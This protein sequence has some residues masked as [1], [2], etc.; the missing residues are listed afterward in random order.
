MPSVNSI[1][2]LYSKRTLAYS[3]AKIVLPLIILSFVACEN[4]M[5]K[6]PA[7]RKKQVGI[8]T[9]NDIESY[10]SVDAKVK[11][12]LTAPYMLRYLADSPYV[13]FHKTMH[14][15]CYN[16]TMHNKTKKNSNYRK[17]IQ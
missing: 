10:Y 5:K 17:Y 3:C 15:D 16:E 1:N 14:V 7:L 2:N 6:I 9:G 12:K 11:A 4:N 8:E 13:E